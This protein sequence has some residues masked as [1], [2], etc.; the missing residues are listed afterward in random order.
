MALAVLRQAKA[1]QPD[2]LPITREVGGNPKSCK[3]SHADLLKH[4]L[5]Y[6]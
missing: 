5:Q 4:H 1:S 2:Q 6:D 3:R